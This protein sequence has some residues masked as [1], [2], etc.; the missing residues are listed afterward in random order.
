VEERDGVIA[1]TLVDVTELVL[2]SVEVLLPVPVDVREPV[3]R[4]LNE[5]QVGWRVITCGA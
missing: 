2:V 4:Q 5:A 1:L 3:C